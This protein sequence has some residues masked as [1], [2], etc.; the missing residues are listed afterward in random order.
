MVFC[1]YPP[2]RSSPHSPHS[3]CVHTFTS[4]RNASHSC[5]KCSY[6]YHHLAPH[7]HLLPGQ[8]LPHTHTHTRIE[9]AD[10][11]RFIL[12]LCIVYVTTRVW[13][14]CSQNGTWC[15]YNTQQTT[16]N[17]IHSMAVCWTFNNSITCRMCPFSL[18][19]LGQPSKCSMCVCSFMCV[20]AAH[21][22][23]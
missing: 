17:T 4:V 13:I 6:I 7:S 2:V 20:R 16:Q 8:E 9:W 5:H 12:Y 11:Y 19:P 21:F 15:Q 22:E 23:D 1:W 10:V 3:K 14:S 18:V